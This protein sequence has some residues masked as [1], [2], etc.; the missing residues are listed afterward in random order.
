MCCDG[1]NYTPQEGDE[2]SECEECGTTLI[3]GEPAD[4][5]NYSPRACST[6]GWRPCDQSC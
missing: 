4:G 1:W 3:D 5:C 2:V 6:C